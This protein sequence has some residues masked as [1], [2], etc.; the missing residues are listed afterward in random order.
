MARKPMSVETKAKIAKSRTGKTWTPE[1]K[2]ARSKML[3]ELHPKAYTW[4]LI[5]PD[6]K[7]YNTKHITAFCKEHNLAYSV[8]RYRA[9]Q[10]DCSPILRG[11]SKGWIVFGIRKDQ[12]QDMPDHLDTSTLPE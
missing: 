2:A 9:Q 7:M 10:N 3:L 5:D 8:L 4:I 1:S 11:P 12:V 6:N